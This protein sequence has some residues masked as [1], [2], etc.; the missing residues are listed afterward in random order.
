MLFGARGGYPGT[1]RAATYATT[2]S[3]LFQVVAALIVF[4]IGQTPFAGIVLLVGVIWYFVLVVI[5]FREIHS[6]S[7]GAATAAA[8]L[9]A[10]VCCGGLALLLVPVFMQARNAALM[11]GGNF[12]NQP[13]FNRTFPGAG[14]NPGFGRPGSSGIPGA[15]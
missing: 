14:Q 13:G 15:F 8:L 4:A 12:G 1:Y 7:T 9:P 3:A 10:L 11:R 2:P 5:G 6:I